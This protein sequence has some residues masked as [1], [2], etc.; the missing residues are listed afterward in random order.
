M[1]FDKQNIKEII[2]EIL[3]EQE[4]Q[5]PIPEVKKPKKTVV[6]FDKST[7]NSFKVVFSQRGFVVNDYKDRLSFEDL[8]NAIAKN[9]NIVLDHGNGINLDVIKMNKILKYK[10]LYKK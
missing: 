1:K 3:K 9:Y 4:T 7:N 2:M 8:E 10:N 6:V 5:N